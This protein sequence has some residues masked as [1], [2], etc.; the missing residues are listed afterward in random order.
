MTFLAKLGGIIAKVVGIFTGFAPLIESA[1]PKSAG[2]IQTV[3]QDLTQIANLVVN[4][5]AIGQLQGLSGP[6]KAKAIAPLVAQI[7]T[8]STIV[9]GHKIAN[10][11]LFLQGC[12]NIGGGMADVLNSLHEDT[13]N[14]VTTP[15]KTS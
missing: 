4:I 8:S 6:D 12:T 10:P 14:A 1:L 2:V 9:A 13:T 11:A 5:E 15:V 7:I 3:S